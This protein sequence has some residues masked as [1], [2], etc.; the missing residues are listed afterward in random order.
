MTEQDALAGVVR[1]IE[2][3]QVAEGMVATFRAGISGYQ[4]L[5][6]EV[7][8]GQIAEITLRNVEIFFA[9]VMLRAA[10]M[11]HGSERPTTSS[12]SSSSDCSSSTTRIR[13]LVTADDGWVLWE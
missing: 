10:T 8:L 11:L 3:A 7:V 6:E 13:G 9:S 2:P 1:R 5:P 4:R 12:T